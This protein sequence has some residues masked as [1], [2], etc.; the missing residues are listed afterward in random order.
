MNQ[1]NVGG[2]VVL[3]AVLVPVKA[4]IVSPFVCRVC[5][6]EWKEVDGFELSFQEVLWSHCS[7][8]D[9]GHCDENSS[10]TQ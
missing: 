1:A 3:V 8:Y 9:E 4:I 10:W 6:N 5:C 2:S 7:C